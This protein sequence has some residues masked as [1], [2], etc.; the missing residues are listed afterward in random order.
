ML[1]F[2]TKNAKESINIL[3]YFADKHGN[4]YYYYLAYFLCSVFQK[5][6]G[7]FGIKK[8]RRKSRKR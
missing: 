4:T 5:N 3:C 8:W 7:I 2:S 6:I 1:C